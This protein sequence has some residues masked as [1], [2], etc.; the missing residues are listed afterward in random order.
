LGEDILPIH[1]VARPPLANWPP[2][3]VLL[4]SG[5]VYLLLRFLRGLSFRPPAKVKPLKAFKRSLAADASRQAALA[6]LQDYCKAV[7]GQAPA[8][9]A[10]LL[11]E[12]DRRSVNA[13]LAGELAER[14]DELNQAVYTGRGQAA[15]PE[16]LGLIARLDKELA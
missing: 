6:A 2:I 15:A 16:L 14:L 5:G 13:A 3:G 7:L 1:L 4:G 8:S 11:S 9:G 12:L 10:E